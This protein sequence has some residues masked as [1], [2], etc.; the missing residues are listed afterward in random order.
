MLHSNSARKHK[1]MGK[2]KV[3]DVLNYLCF[4]FQFKPLKICILE[5]LPL[6]GVSLIPL[7]TLDVNI[8][9]D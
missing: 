2:H 7:N 8:G 4:L 3:M 9:F 5:D 1:V 6:S